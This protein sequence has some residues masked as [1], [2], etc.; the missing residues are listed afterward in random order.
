M[1]SV[2]NSKNAAI[3]HIKLFKSYFGFFF[4]CVCFPIFQTS[5]VNRQTCA[6]ESNNDETLFDINSSHCHNDVSNTS[7]PSK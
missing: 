3:D 1:N 2:G 7:Y 5:L 6:N 4:V